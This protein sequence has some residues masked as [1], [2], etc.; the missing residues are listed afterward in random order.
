MKRKINVLFLL[1]LLSIGITLAQTRVTG[2]VAD[3][4]GEPVIGAS[5]QIKG[6][7]Q[8]TVTDIDG[9]FTLSAPPNG[10]LVIK[11]VFFLKEFKLNNGRKKCKVINWFK[12]I[13][14]DDENILCEIY[15][16]KNSFKE[17]IDNSIKK[18]A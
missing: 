3:E 9:D 15:L 2:H 11:K 7:G 16:D 18:S 12:R 4:N 14:I 8:G 13:E 6:T 17:F 10:T 5:I 1:L